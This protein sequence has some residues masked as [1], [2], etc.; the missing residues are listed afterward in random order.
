[1]SRQLQITQGANVE[2]G[3]DV[4]GGI[5]ADSI[6]I[7]GAPVGGTVHTDS[8]LT[9]DGSVGDP[10]SVVGGG[11]IHTSAPLSGDGSVSTPATIA[12]GAIA[13]TKLATQASGTILAN[14]TGGTVSPTAVAPDLTVGFTASGFGLAGWWANQERF[15]ASKLT[16]LTEFVP[17]K[18]GVSQIGGPTTLVAGNGTDASI[19]GGG[20]QGATGAVVNYST[21]T[22]WQSPKTGVVGCVWRAKYSAVSA[23]V[24]DIGFINAAGTHFITLSLVS[25]VDATKWYL[26]LTAAAATNLAFV[27]ADTAWHDF[28]ITYDGTAGT[29]TVT[30]WVDGVIIGTQTTLTNFTTDPLYPFHLNQNATSPIKVSKALWGYVAP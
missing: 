27:V 8:T 1:M 12:A 3:L 10:L 17:W 26:S 22:V 9:G 25:S 6:L 7:N 19:E 16:A 2:L 14:A 21:A 28:A 5:T 13:L 18:A 20:Q 23:N 15:L 11:T 24:Q 29:P 4:K 30:V